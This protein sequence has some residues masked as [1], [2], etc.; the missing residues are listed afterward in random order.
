M[1]TVIAVHQKQNFLPL[2][3]LPQYPERIQE[4]N[5]SWS[6]LRLQPNLP[7]LSKAK[8][9]WTNIMCHVGLGQAPENPVW[10]IQGSAGSLLCF[11]M[12]A[13]NSLKGKLRNNSVACQEDMLKNQRQENP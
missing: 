7:Q 13:I 5:E 9:D 11:Y 8:K 2:D 6:K 12:L 4:Q 10:K 3:S 1:S